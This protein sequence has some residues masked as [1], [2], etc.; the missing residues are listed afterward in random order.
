[1]LGTR[2]ERVGTRFPWFYGPDFLWF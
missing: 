1:M 2:Y